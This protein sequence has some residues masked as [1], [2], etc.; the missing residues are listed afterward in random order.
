M[1]R[2]L[3]VVFLIMFP[4]VSLLGCSGRDIVKNNISE[5]TNYY[6]EGLSNQGFVSSI[7]VGR[8]ENP[9]AVDGIHNKMCDFS[10]VSLKLQEYLGDEIKVKLLV[11]G[12]EQNINLFYHPINSLYINDLGYALNKSDRIKLIFNEKE[13]IF[14]EISENFAVNMKKAIKIA[15]IKLSNEIN[16]LMQ[17]DSFLGE[18]YLKILAK[19]DDKNLY[20]CFTLISRKGESHNVLI[21]VYDEDKVIFM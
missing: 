9:Y 1:K 19:N 3:L 12:N 5:I 8:R 16:R 17:N 20:W 21:S 14:S 10:L 2:F 6:F 18:F 4:F 13:V 11:N 7:S 15:K